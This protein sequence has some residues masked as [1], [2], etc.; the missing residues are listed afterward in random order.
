VPQSGSLLGEAPPAAGTP[1]LEALSER[2]E[3]RSGLT[4]R[5][6]APLWR[7]R[8]VAF[9][10]TAIPDAPAIPASQWTPST[11]SSPFLCR[12]TS[13]LHVIVADKGF[14]NKKPFGLAWKTG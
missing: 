8:A 9:L 6:D 1:T 11:D 5:L 14:L 4:F 2:R 7:P 12:I 10:G 13:M 3:C